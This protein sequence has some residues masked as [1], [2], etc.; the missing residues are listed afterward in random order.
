MI[1]NFFPNISNNT[2]YLSFKNLELNFSVKFMKESLI[3]Y[4]FFRNFPPKI[5]LIKFIYNKIF[6]PF[7]I[8]FI[9]LYL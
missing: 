4:S 3:L 7:Y 1:N 5:D 6:I 8:I 9:K 2:G